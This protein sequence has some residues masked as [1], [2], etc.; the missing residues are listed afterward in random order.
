MSSKYG[1]IRNDFF[2]EE[3]QKWNIDAWFTDDGSE[4]GV[5]IAKVDPVTKEVEYI[6]D[7]ARYDYYAQEV[8]AETL[9]F[10]PE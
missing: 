3:E 6:D 2:D 4:E 5:V 8:I 10:S 9:E 7:D 1:E